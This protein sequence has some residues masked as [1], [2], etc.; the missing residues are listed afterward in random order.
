MVRNQPVQAP[1]LT[2][3]SSQGAAFDFLADLMAGWRIPWQ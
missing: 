3:E 1:E 2:L